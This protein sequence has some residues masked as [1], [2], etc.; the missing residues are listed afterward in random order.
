MVKVEPK[1]RTFDNFP[2]E[3]K[4]KVNKVKATKVEDIGELFLDSVKQK[5]KFN[6]VKN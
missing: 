6:K 4:K 2:D 5:K 3:K 1:L